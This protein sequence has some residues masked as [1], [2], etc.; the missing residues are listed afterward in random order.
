MTAKSGVSRS[1]IA[2]QAGDA[3]DTAVEARLSF[4]HHAP[5]QLWAARHATLISVFAVPVREI[6]LTGV[7]AVSF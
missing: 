1:R 7:A 3:P 2:R 5:R 4:S 6:A